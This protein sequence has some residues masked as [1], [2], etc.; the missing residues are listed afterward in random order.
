MGGGEAD[1]REGSRGPVP[2]KPLTK[3]EPF[4]ATFRSAEMSHPNL[5]AP[6]HTKGLPNRTL[7]FLNLPFLAF[8]EFIAFFSCKIFLAFL[9]VFRSFPKDL[10]VSPGKANPCFFGRFPCFFLLPK[11]QGKED[12]G[13]I[14]NYFR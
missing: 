12:Q 6:L 11:K 1:S 14:L 7:L 8:L 2:N 4:G 3:L 5:W 13:I 10:R 9:I